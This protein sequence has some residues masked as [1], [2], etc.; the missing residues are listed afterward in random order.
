M[1]Q[2]EKMRKSRVRRHVRVRKRLSGTAE[3]PRLVVHR[4]AKNISAQII[5][6]V[7]GKTLVSAA[8]FDKK[9][10][11]SLKSGGNVEAAKAVGAQVAKLAKDISI[12]R[13]VFD[14]GGY[15]YHGR[16]RSLAE[17]ARENGLQF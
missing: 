10:R 11:P 3:R 5:D 1:N 14:R 16:I 8:S 15:P 13:V 4:S 6:D 12:T 17:S 9:L 2:S 7:A